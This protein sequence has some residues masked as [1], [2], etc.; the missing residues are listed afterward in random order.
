MSG[1]IQ[2][3]ITGFKRSGGSKLILD[4]RNN[5]AVFIVLIVCLLFIAFVVYS[6]WFA[7]LACLG[8]GV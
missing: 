2:D 7:Y 4:L 3:A 6:C 1:L 8:V 5:G